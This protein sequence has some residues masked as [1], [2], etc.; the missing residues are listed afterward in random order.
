MPSL[1]TSGRTTGAVLVGSSRAGAG[2]S[3]RVAAWN[4]NNQSNLGST[5]YAPG[6]AANGGYGGG[7]G[8]GA[9]QYAKN[10]SGNGYS[11][12]NGGQGLVCIWANINQT[13][14]TSSISGIAASPQPTIPRPSAGTTAILN[15]TS[16]N[17]NNISANSA[18]PNSSSGVTSVVYNGETYYVIYL[19]PGVFTIETN[20]S[21][22]NI[23]MCGA[24]GGGAGGASLENDNCLL[25]AGGGGGGAIIAGTVYLYSVQSS[26]TGNNNLG[27][28]STIQVSLGYGG[29]G[30]GGGYSNGGNGYSG[31][32]GNTGS[33]TQV[34]ITQS[35]NSQISQPIYFGCPGGGG[36]N[37]A[38][39]NNSSGN[40]SQPQGGTGGTPN[41]SGFSSEGYSLL[42]GFLSGGNGGNGTYGNY[43]FN[44]T[45]GGAAS[46]P[47]GTNL[48]SGIPTYSYQAFGIPAFNSS[49]PYQ[50]A[51]SG[52]TFDGFIPSAAAINMGGGG[53]G[54]NAYLN[55]GSNLLGGNGAG[56]TGGAVNQS[57]STGSGSVTQNVFGWLGNTILGALGLTDPS[58][59]LSLIFE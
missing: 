9:P 36:G 23:A 13:N 1:G 16:A 17:T 18:Y 39:T 35:V 14:T 27:L 4:R 30:G 2:S 12:G 49:I 6:S 59:Y 28:T 26:G 15:V 3:A 45:A 24:G 53:G 29:A 7:G 54:S 38:S 56:G 50:G 20:L 41:V 32:N 31:L 21:V 5:P 44:N 22:I 25:G 47:T 33:A 48:P 34:T 10:G 52:T 8:G 37:A 51:P 42:F 19:G 58:T 11:G 55:S 43:N 57:N 40:G 46:Q